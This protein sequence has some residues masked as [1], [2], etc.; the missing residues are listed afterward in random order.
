[1][2]Y[3]GVV[4]C[5]RVPSG[6]FV[7]RRN[8][9][10]FVTGNSGF[11]KSL[12]V[13]KA[14]DKAAGAERNVAP[15]TRGGDT[16]FRFQAGGT[17]SAP[18]VTPDALAWQGWGTALKPA[19]EFW[20][21]ARK[22]LSEPTVAA[23]VLRW[24]TGALNV[25]GC[26]VE[27]VGES[28]S[29]ARRASARRSGNTPTSDRSAAEAQA[30]GRI[31]NRASP[32][33]FM[34]PRPGEALGR[35][36]A[37]LV[38]S[39]SQECFEVGT[40]TVRGSN[41]KPSDVGL[42]REG[43]HTKGIYGAKASK[44]TVSHTDDDG[45][46]VVPLFACVPGC[47]VRMLDDQSG[48]SVSRVGKPRSSQAPGDGWGMTATGAEYTDTGGASRYF[49]VVDWD[50]SSTC[51]RTESGTSANRFL[52][53]S[54]A[55]RRER[56]RGLDPE[57]F[58]KGSTHPTVKPLALMRWLIR[59]VTPPG[60]IILDPFAGSGT[61]LI[62]AKLEGFS[63]YGIEREAEYVQIARARLAAWEPK[64]GS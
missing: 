32:E 23:N 7:A 30:E 17:P 5:V 14:I 49:K 36:P 22:P 28:P 3:A 57:T 6:A 39:H 61:T 4:W 52:Y 56:N 59:L 51:E 10:I 31:E 25:D 18:P 2:E 64:E 54:K 16:G 41:T 26:R 60:G 45:M 21:L 37:N 63:A 43:D 1:V 33:V 53:T 50:E 38:L 58:P 27:T 40:R 44:V 13:S 62:A 19:V 46:E 24:G 29:E 12:D 11:P 47:S 20:T 35:W 34:A 8:G 55:S 15:H 42:G 9:L 48:K